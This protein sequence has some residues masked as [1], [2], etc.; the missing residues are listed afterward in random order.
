MGILSEQKGQG[1]GFMMGIMSAVM[2]AIILAAMLP[3]LN[4]VVTTIVAG[5]MSA[6]SN[7][8]TILML[9]GMTGLIVVIMFIYGII[10]GFM[11]P[12]SSQGGF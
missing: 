10:Q 8:A 12:Q 4:S 3:A 9:L 6:F 7:S 2:G 11:N 5:N 1:G